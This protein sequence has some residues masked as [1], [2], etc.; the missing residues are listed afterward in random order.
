MRVVWLFEYPTLNGGE[1]SLLAALPLLRQEGIQPVALAPARGP[2]AEELDRQSVE[3]L[4][5]DVSDSN[6][7]KMS[8]DILRESLL[9]RLRSMRPDVLHANSLSMG[10]LSGPVAQSAEVPSIT[11]LRDIVGLSRAAI[12]DLNCHTRLLAVSQ[13]TLDFH[14]QQ[15]VD[16]EK[17]FVC[18]NGVDLNRFRP[19]P[20]TGWLHRQLALPSDSILAATIG[21]VIM[22]K[23]QDVLIRAAASLK[24]I[25]PKLHWLIIGERYSQKAEAIQFEANLRTHV[26]AKELSNHVH[27]L[28]NIDRIEEV[29]PELT[30]LVHPARQEPLGRVLLE[31][32]ASGVACVATDVGGTREIFPDTGMAALVPA[33]Y[34]EALKSAVLGLI[35]A[36]DRRESMSRH[37]RKHIQSA[38]D[39]MQSA[40]LLCDHYR[41][42]AAVADSSRQNV[43]AE[44]FSASGTRQTGC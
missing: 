39:I 43:T 6:G 4:A 12:A 23:G 26:A 2:L 32:A 31:A 17:M 28:G 34:H 13:T 38:F 35:L 27:F 3:R 37:A 19:R 7:Q 16:A 1:R 29:L 20:A 8:R 5:F 9:A 22:R 14:R 24:D 15:G 41:S 40:K 42:V 18:Y 44:R 36:P 11:H 30:L 33:D 21:Q 25:L 10:R